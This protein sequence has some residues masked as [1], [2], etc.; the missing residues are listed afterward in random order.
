MIYT[1]GN[2]MY[3]RVES[4]WEVGTRAGAGPE[5]PGVVQFAQG[6]QAH[7]AEMR[8]LSQP[9]GGGVFSASSLCFNGALAHDPKMSRILLNAV[10]AA[11]LQQLEPLHV[12][13]SGSGA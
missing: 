12:D 1:G 5:A 2:G 4:G 9:N 3:E 6:E 7:G 11:Q 13:G 10:K 8:V